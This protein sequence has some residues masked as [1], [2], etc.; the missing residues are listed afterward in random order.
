MLVRGAGGT[1]PGA[2]RSL[3]SRRRCPALNIL[4][5]ILKNFAKRNGQ[6]GE[7][8]GAQGEAWPSRGPNRGRP[9]PTRF[10][11]KLL[12]PARFGGDHM[13]WRQAPGLGARGLRGF[14]P[15][16]RPARPATPRTSALEPKPRCRV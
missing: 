5:P 2:I 12:G 9:S 6:Y 11:A 15:R 8:S 10:G 1:L 3:P 7:G 16:R 4:A 14:T 13:A